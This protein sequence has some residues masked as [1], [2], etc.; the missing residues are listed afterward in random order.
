MLSIQPTTSGSGTE[1]RNFVICK[2]NIR[3]KVHLETRALAGQ[4][5]CSVVLRSED[6]INGINWCVWAPDIATGQ[7]SDID[8]DENV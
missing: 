7:Y 3:Q 4:S 2:T 6:R 5:V 1:K 8:I